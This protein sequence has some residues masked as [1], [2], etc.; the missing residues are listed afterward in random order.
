MEK[1]RALT[2][3]KPVSPSKYLQSDVVEVTHFEV[4]ELKKMLDSIKMKNEALPTSA[5]MFIAK[6]LKKVD[7]LLQKLNVQKNEIQST[8]LQ[9]DNKGFFAFWDKHE[10]R[11][12]A[13]GVEVPDN[14]QAINGIKAFKVTNPQG[15]P[16]FIDYFTNQPVLSGKEEQLAIYVSGGEEKEKEFY[17]AMDSHEK[18]KHELHVTRVDHDYL[19]N[20]RVA[21]P[22][23]Y[24]TQNGVQPI[25]MVIF[26]ENLV[27]GAVESIEN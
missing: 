22:T 17:A 9:I 27:I 26:F 5:A 18:Q 12:N 13:E 25:N 10:K 4:E 2:L 1:I 11:T 16:V 23:K 6:N 20:C 21:I 19:E 3:E 7:A 24:V 15:K 14:E 8:Y